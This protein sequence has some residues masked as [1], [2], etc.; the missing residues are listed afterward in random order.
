MT[1]SKFQDLIAAVVATIALLVA[2]VWDI[3]IY[4]Q[5]YGFFLKQGSSHHSIAATVLA[6]DTSSPAVT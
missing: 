1:P 3:Y 4:I 5:I 2:A 6:S